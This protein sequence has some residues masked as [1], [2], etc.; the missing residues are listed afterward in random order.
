MTDPA[1]KYKHITYKGQP[2]R[3]YP[4]GSIRNDKGHLMA[5]HPKATEAIKAALA[6]QGNGTPKGDLTDAEYGEGMRLVKVQKQTERKQEAQR[7]AELGLLEAA[8]SASPGDPNVPSEAWGLLASNMAE[9]AL[10]E[11]NTGYAV[12]A[13]KLIGQMTGY[14]GDDKQRPTQ[15][16][17]NQQ[18]NIQFDS[19]TA[20]VWT[21]IASRAIEGEVREVESS[22]SQSPDNYQGEEEE[23]GI[24][25]EGAEAEQAEE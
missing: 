4:D 16:I 1:P 8:R 20:E 24:G 25:D 15:H 7:Q 6:A 14:M 5:R 19:S 10:L 21:D 3:Q 9:R 2:A 13:T 22:S 23:Q 18:V 12:S 17:E 11:D